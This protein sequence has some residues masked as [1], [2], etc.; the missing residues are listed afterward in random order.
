MHLLDCGLRSFGPP[1]AQPAETQNPTQT[2]A[3]LSLTWPCL[4]LEPVLS[5]CTAASIAMVVFLVLGQ[6]Y[7]VS[8]AELARAPQSVLAEAAACRQEDAPITVTGWQQPSHW[9]FQVSTRLLPGLW[10]AVVA[11]S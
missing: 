9:A 11:P 1:P 6:H 2:L 7:S 4:A 3:L 5:L 8:K 10:R